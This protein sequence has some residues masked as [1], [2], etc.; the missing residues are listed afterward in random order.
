MC[1]TCVILENSQLKFPCGCVHTVTRATSFLDN[2]QVDKTKI[3][4]LCPGY[5]CQTKVTVCVDRFT[6]LVKNL[7]FSGSKLSN[8]PLNEEMTN[9]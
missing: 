6:D 5:G 3:I 1:K 8:I 9:H 4:G 7:I 2:A